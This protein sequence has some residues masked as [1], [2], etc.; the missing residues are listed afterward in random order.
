VL[1]G[2][3]VTGAGPHAGDEEARRFDLDI[4]SATRVHSLVVLAAIAATAALAVRIGR[5]PADQARLATLVSAWI[6]IGVVQGAVGYVQY[7]NEI[8]AL[9]VGI[10]VAG[11]TVLFVVTVQL[12]LATT[13]ATTLPRSDVDPESGDDLA[14]LAD[15]VVE[16]V[17]HRDD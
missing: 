16:H 7:F 12:V 3:L 15:G 13:V 10:H 11:A 6:L 17:G 5:R 9:L 14:Q 4:A 8:P 1:A 2:T